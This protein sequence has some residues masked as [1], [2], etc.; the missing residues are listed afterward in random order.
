MPFVFLSAVCIEPED[1]T[2]KIISLLDNRVKRNPTF[3]FANI[4]H[5]QKTLKISTTRCRVLIEVFRFSVSSVF[6]H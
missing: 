3:F 4:Q 5:T 1:D 2:I 6:M